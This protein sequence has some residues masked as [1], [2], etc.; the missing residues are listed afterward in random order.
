MELQQ[1]EDG[2][3][4]APTEAAFGPDPEIGH[5]GRGCSDSAPRAVHSILGMD[6]AEEQFGARGEVQPF[7]RIAAVRS[8]AKSTI[9][10][11]SRGS[12]LCLPPLSP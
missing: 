12:M 4:I 6:Q 1:R 5:G 3:G 7:Q 2:C 11:V 9:T 10:L 8:L